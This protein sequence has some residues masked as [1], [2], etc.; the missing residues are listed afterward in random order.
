MVVLDLGNIWS[1][2]IKVKTALRRRDIESG[3]DFDV[4]FP[5]RAAKSKTTILNQPP[6]Y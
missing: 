6:K 5:N 2:N 3:L 4:L 1:E